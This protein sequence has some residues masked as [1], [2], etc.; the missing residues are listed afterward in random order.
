MN[1]L[2]VI[3]SKVKETIETAAG[4]LIDKYEKK[5]DENSLQLNPPNFDRMQESSLTYVYDYEPKGGL[6][7]ARE[8]TKPEVTF[9]SSQGPLSKDAP[10]DRFVATSM[11][12]DIGT[13]SDKPYE[14]RVATTV[15]KRD[16]YASGGV[17]Q[18]DDSA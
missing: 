11:A 14:F 10:D 17:N 1:V 7:G 4:F 5:K 6:V 13:L 16:I 18:K 15:S 12:N 8:I 2:T 9:Q 3:G